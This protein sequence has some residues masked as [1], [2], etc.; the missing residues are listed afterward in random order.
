MKI[1]K[2]K[3]DRRHNGFSQW[4]YFVTLQYESNIYQWRQDFFLLRNWCWDTWGASKEISE[5]MKD[6]N[7]ILPVA[8][9]PHWC[10]QND[11][12][13]ARLYFREDRDLSEFALVWL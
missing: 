8:Q 10:W 4:K 7:Q 1:R 3:L 5:W 9:N 6:S 11:Q 13:H 12:Y 2:K